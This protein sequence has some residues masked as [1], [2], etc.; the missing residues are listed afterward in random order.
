[1]GQVDFN[2]ILL[3]YVDGVSKRKEKIGSPKQLS[4]VKTG[5]NSWKC[6]IFVD[7]SVANASA[8]L[9]LRIKITWRRLGRPEIGIFR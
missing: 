5:L 3:L 4:E 1:M 2:A 9:L 7:K 8:K 6:G